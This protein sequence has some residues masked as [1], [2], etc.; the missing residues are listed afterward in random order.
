MVYEIIPTF[1]RVGF[2]PLTVN[3]QGPF[4]QLFHFSNLITKTQKHRVIKALALP[5][6]EKLQK[7]GTHFYPYTSDT[8]DT[9][10]KRLEVCGKYIKEAYGV[11]ASWS[12]L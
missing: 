4:V 11:P 3:N 6:D 10:G 1:N 12:Y 7:F 5:A 8:T 2:H 9:S